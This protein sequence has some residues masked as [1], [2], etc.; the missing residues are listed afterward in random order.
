MLFRR[1]KSLESHQWR[2]ESREPSE[3]G[4]RSADT[5][6]TLVDSDLSPPNKSVKSS[7]RALFSSKES[8]AARTFNKKVLSDNRPFSVQIPSRAKSR[9]PFKK[10]SRVRGLGMRRKQPVSCG[11]ETKTEFERTISKDSSSFPLTRRTSFASFSSTNTFVAQKPDVSLEVSKRHLLEDSISRRLK[12]VLQPRFKRA[13]R[14]LT[15]VTAKLVAGTERLGRFLGRCTLLILE[16]IAMCI[17]IPFFIAG[18]IALW[19]GVG[20]ILS[21]LAHI[22][23]SGFVITGICL[24]VLQPLYLILNCCP[25]NSFTALLKSGLDGVI[26]IIFV[27][28]NLTLMIVGWITNW[29]FKD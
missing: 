20:A 13:K 24:V 2:N 26:Q 6:M 27:L 14:E 22:T 15:T 16:M 25:T 1:R 10:L 18:K 12:R 23:L 3:L 28:P 29:V 11:Q 8:A 21:G 9:W 7:L 5:E 19:L 4:I 17:V